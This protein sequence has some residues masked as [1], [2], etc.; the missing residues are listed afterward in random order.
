MVLPTPSWALS[1]TT[2]VG[3][4]M[5]VAR[6][7]PGTPFTTMVTV[8]GAEPG[9]DVALAVDVVQDDGR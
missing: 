4:S 2:T 5:K 7:L 6:S 1:L 9:A 3:P 8:V